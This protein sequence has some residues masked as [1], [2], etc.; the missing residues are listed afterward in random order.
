MNGFIT[1]S[2]SIYYVNNRKKVIFGGKLTSPVQYSNLL[3]MVGGS[4][5]VY[6]PDGSI[7]TTGI[8][9]KYI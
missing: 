9:V 7:I 6:L 3:C 4:A 2:G 1:N 5:H 8:V